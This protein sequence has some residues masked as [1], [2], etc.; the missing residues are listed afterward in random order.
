MEMYKIN[1]ITQSEDDQNSIQKIET[2]LK[3]L[4]P[5]IKAIHLFKIKTLEAVRMEARYYAL[6]LRLRELRFPQTKDQPNG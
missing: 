5:K 4:G 6:T 1:L 2:L 3:E